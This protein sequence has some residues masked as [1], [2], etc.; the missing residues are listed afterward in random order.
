MIKL[1]VGYIYSIVKMPAP[2]CELY[3]VIRIFT[4]KEQN[5]I[6]ILKELCEVYGNSCMNL[7]T[8]CWWR[9]WFLSGCNHLHYESRSGWPVS[10]T[11]NDDVSTVSVIVNTNRQMMLDGIVVLL[12]KEIK[13]VLEF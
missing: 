13:L 10:A 12:S 8:V 7:Q 1:T 2:N 5:T 9:A 11:D 3:S 4:E 6:Q